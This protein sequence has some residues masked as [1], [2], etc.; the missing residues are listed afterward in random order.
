MSS[1]IARFLREEE[2]GQDLTE[3]CL[4]TAFIALVFLGIVW[5]V[6]GG[7]QGMWTSINNSVAAGNGGST[8]AGGR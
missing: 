3:Y 7:L 6:S 8:S 2:R 4:V 1:A 5:H